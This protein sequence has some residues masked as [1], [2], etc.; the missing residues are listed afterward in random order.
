MAIE[1]EKSTEPKE[2]SESPEEVKAEPLDESA[3]P[4]SD[5]DEDELQVDASELIDDSLRITAADETEDKQP[6]RWFVWV[7][8][9]FKQILNY[10]FL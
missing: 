4:T 6:S 8:W 7:Y 5:N 3:Q 1:K 10:W 9:K 2:K